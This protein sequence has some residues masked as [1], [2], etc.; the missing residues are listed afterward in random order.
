MCHG[1]EYSV[2]RV[3]LIALFGAANGF[4]ASPMYFPLRRL[5]PSRWEGDPTQRLWLRFVPDRPLRYDDPFLRASGPEMDCGREPAGI[6]QSAGLDVP[7]RVRGRS[8]E[9]GYSLVPHSGQNQHS[10]TLVWLV[11]RVNMAGVPLVMRTFS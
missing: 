8:R 10:I 5:P 1:M 6:I 7:V 4:L 9:R 3:N 2:S 11:R